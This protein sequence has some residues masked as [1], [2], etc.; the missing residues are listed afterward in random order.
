MRKT[1]LN[2]KQHTRLWVTVLL[3]THSELRS[4][5]RKTSSEFGVTSF[6]VLAFALTVRKC[7]FYY[8]D[9]W[10]VMELVYRW[11]QQELHS[12]VCRLVRHCAKR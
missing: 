3:H 7:L 11:V 4:K 5:P 10:A 12:C 9:I 1:C 2:N 8:S 6:E